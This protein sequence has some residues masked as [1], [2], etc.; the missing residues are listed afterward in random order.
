MWAQ[1]RRQASPAPP[2]PRW[3]LAEVALDF[4]I[5]LFY[6]CALLW[7]CL[8]PCWKQRPPTREGEQVS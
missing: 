3:Q 8:D 6:F 7:P 1:T 2:A 5:F 4:L